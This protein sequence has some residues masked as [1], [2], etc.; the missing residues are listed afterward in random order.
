M[1]RGLAQHITEND[2][3]NYLVMSSTDPIQSVRVIQ[4]TGTIILLLFI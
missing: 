2:V 1:I 4:I 3:S